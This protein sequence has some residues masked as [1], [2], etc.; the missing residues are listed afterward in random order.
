M[1][2]FIAEV[3]PELHRREWRT[4]F[5]EEILPTDNGKVRV[6]DFHPSDGAIYNRGVNRL[7]LLR[8]NSSVTQFPGSGDYGE[9]GNRFDN[10]E[11]RRAVTGSLKFRI[12]NVCPS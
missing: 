6:V 11:G 5:L 3:D 1:G 4:G 7:S 9:A 2:D 10:Y 8:P 12:K